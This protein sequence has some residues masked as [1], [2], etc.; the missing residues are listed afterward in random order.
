[1]FILILLVGFFIG[2]ILGCA[3]AVYASKESNKN[4]S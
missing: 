4:D 3:W 2:V 1:M